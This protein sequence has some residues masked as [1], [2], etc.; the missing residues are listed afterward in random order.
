MSISILF[1][2][3]V[4]ISQTEGTK[5]GRFKKKKEKRGL[6]RACIL[7]DGKKKAPSSQR[8]GCRNFKPFLLYYFYFIFIFFNAITLHYC[9]IF[10]LS[11]F[12]LIFCFCTCIV[13]FLS[14]LTSR[15]FLFSPYSSVYFFFFLLFL[16]P[17]SKCL[18]EKILQ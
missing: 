6:E 15:I 2:F 4:K 13:L 8:R 5:G 10:Y 3:L 11:F 7:G 17:F 9:T 14:I 16:S 18:H 12:S 1:I